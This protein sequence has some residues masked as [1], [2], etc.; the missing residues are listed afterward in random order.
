ML[1][2]REPQNECTSRLSIFEGVAGN[3]SIRKK[4]CPATPCVPARRDG[5][6]VLFLSVLVY[7]GSSFE[8]YHADRFSL[9]SAIDVSAGL[10][11]T[12]GK[13]MTVPQLVPRPRVFALRHGSRAL[14]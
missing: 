2:E 12:A 3:P 13:T 14:R 10:R 5:P 7:P 9:A 4:R 6:Y 8:V 11:V 1:G